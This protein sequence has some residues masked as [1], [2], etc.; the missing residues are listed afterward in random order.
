[1]LF[2]SM[3]GNGTGINRLRYYGG[4]F[5]LRDEANSRDM[6]SINSLTCTVVDGMNFAFN[7]TTGTK[8]GT[9]TTQK[10][11]FFN[12]TPIVQPANTT[13][14]RV[15]LINLGLL[16]SGGATPLDLN[17]G[18]LTANSA[19]LSALTQG[20]VLFA[21]G[22]GAVSQKNAS[23]FW[24]NS[25]NR[26]GIGTAS[27]SN[28]LHVINDVL[29][30]QNASNTGINV[31][32]KGNG[33]GVNRV[34]TYQAFRLRDE[35]AGTD[36]FYMDGSGNFGLNGLSAGGGVFV[37]FIAN[38]TTLPTTNPSGGGILYVD[39]GALKYRG[40]SGTVTTIAPA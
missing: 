8:F 19:T 38:A 22:S 36:R 27:P 34:R 6:L 24:D 20:S 12:A 1:M 10:I 28:A 33:S 30:E 7:T 18:A 23:F 31:Y 35:T 40:S 26:L 16:A 14:L 29:F 4:L 11:G 15:T 25:N 3:K 5:A 37:C 21:G 2:R 17:G 32:L 13:D 9:A 39:S